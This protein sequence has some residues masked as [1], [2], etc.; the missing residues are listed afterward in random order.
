MREILDR[1]SLL[2]AAVAEV[3]ELVG[4][5]EPRSNEV[6]VC[7]GGGGHVC[8]VAF[9]STVS[10]SPVPWGVRMTL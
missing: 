1:L 7:G 2:P 4:T 5:V 10:C 3:K 8:V 9:A 6:C